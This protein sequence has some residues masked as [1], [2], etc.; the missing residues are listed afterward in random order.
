M[1]P[2]SGYQCE[3]PGVKAD[4]SVKF[5]WEDDGTQVEKQRVS[6]RTAEKWK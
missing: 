3:G 6:Q 4:R 5:I 1:I 2:L